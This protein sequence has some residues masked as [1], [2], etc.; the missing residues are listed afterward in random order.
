MENT[1]EQPTQTF[2]QAF[3]DG[4]IDEVLEEILEEAKLKKIEQGEVTEIIAN[5]FLKNGL[6]TRDKKNSE[7]LS[8]VIEGVFRQYKDKIKEVKI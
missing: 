2:D 3:I 6:E 5:V 4:L 8:G 1:T 7:L